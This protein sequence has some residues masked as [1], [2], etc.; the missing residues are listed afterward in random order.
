VCALGVNGGHDYSHHNRDDYPA[1]SMSNEAL[2]AVSA[3][4]DSRHRA[5]EA[6]REV[7][8]AAPVAGASLRQIAA[9][10]LSHEQV[11]RIVHGDCKVPHFV[12]VERRG[13]S[14]LE[15]QLLVRAPSK[16]AAGEFASW[17]AER[18]RAGFFEATKVRR[19]ARK[20]STLPP[21][22]FDDADL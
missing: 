8:R 19:A 2:R 15:V 14:P 1:R 5:E 9:A 18:R 20:E 21:T 3:A 11:R 12:T 10:P 6:Q 4:A 13:V 22:A 16:Q 7:T 17:I